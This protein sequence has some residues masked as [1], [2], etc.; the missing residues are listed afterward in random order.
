[1][2]SPF[3]FLDS[4]TK[5]DR[6]F[7]FGR[8][9][10]IE[11]LYHRVFE[12]KI[13]LVYG[14]SGTGKSSLIHCGLANKFAETDW[15]PLVIRRGGNIIDSM[16]AGINSASLTTQ[17]SKFSTPADFRKSVRSLY[18][19]HYKP[20][21]FIFDQ[22]EE[23]FIFGDKEERRNFIHIVKTLTESDL[24]CRF[25]FVMRE[26]YM[27]NFT[28]FERIIPAIFQNRVRIEKMSHRNA[29]DAIKG[30]CKVFNINLE[31]GF[32]ET[33]LEKLSPG[34]EDVELTYLQV[35]LDKIFKIA[36]E[37]AS[38]KH[39]E[40]NLS[41]TL[42]LLNR[43]GN[44]SDLLGSFLDE[45]IALMNDQETALMILKSMVSIQ[46]TKRQLTTEEVEENMISFGRKTDKTLLQEMLQNFV[47]LRILRDKDEN[48]KMEFRHDALA[49][50]I[51]EK[52]TIAEKELLEVRKYIENA[53]YNFEKRGILLN[54]QDLDYL[55]D[56]ENKL[57][58]P[59]N[60]EIF[61]S[62]SKK[63]IY[64][65]RKA[66]RRITSIS[67]LIFIL[68]LAVTLRFYLTSQ[69]SENVNNLFRSALIKSATDPVK[70]LVAEIDLWQKD[71]TSGQ[72]HSIIIKDFQRVIQMQTDTADPVYLI[73]KNLKPFKFES[74]VLHAEM[75]NPGLFMTGWLENQN[76]FVINIR[77]KESHCFKA[78]SEIKHI[79]ISENNLMLAI[80]YSNNNVSVCDF[81]GKKLFGFKTKINEVNND[82]L[83]CFSPSKDNGIVAIKDSLI[84]IYD[85]SGKITGQLKGHN[86]NVNSVDISPDG[87]FIVAAGDDCRGYLW[88]Y[89]QETGKYSVYDSL[90]GHKDRIWSCRFNKTGK[91]VITASAD[92]TIKIWDLNGTHINSGFNFILNKAR[93]RLNAGEKDEDASSPRFA[94]YYGRFCDAYFSVSELEI[95]ATGY[96]NLRDSVGNT[97]TDYYKVLF[98]DG[99]GGFP[100]GYKRSLFSGT[101][102][103]DDIRIM[104]F[105][106]FVLSP[107]DKIA[108][109]VDSTSSNVF[110]VT[111]TDYILDSFNGRNPMFSS[112]EN[113]FYWISGETIFMSPLYPRTIN[114]IIE[115][116]RK[117]I[118]SGGFSFV[119]M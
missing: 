35:F 25:I 74:P 103:Q 50:K 58:L 28:E 38:S 42:A 112:V 59:K 86:K 15:L 66:L 57:I 111:G 20:V 91:Y 46:G 24:Q 80:V 11:E 100:Y 90:I 108:A 77:N 56:Y 115:P 3:K 114:E 84:F 101:P 109:V 110:L 119:E 79:E 14:V 21:F 39:D 73:R 118:K 93:Y 54:K 81:S 49:S 8:E 51:Y 88:S 116:L 40:Q 95:I 17:Q 87:K 64:S 113:E 60:L 23:L 75:G 92:S 104:T 48:G 62:D 47:N 18:L 19:D 99:V 44:V 45:Q 106:E 52:F 97:K 89:N 10:E 12:S 55:A 22:F 69:D 37:A 67:T 63:R 53:L 30:P 7:F 13:M 78:E 98:Y 94:K 105:S 41:F 83:V 9:R 27:A 5:D 117:S 4:Y 107:D 70:G 76:V 6:E 72:L 32:A 61:I 65:Q 71:S 102:A 31:E 33:L 2:K 16:T 82:K 29:I 96:N 68:I 36:V 85:N 34:S 1:M 26:E 43:I